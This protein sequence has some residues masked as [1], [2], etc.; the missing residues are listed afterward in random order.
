ME[1]TLDQSLAGTLCTLCFNLVWGEASDIIQG[2]DYC[3]QV[4]D[5]S[6]DRVS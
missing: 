6:I 4:G 3:S 5:W 1:T 2:G